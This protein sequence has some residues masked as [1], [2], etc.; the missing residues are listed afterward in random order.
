MRGRLRGE[1]EE[2]KKEAGELELIRR[3][4]RKTRGG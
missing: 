1:R 3:R 2:E 4:K